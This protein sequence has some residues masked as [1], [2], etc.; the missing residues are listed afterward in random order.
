[1]EMIPERFIGADIPSLGYIGDGVLDALNDMFSPEE[2]PKALLL[3][4]PAG[5]GKTYAMHAIVKWIADQDPEKCVFFS[6]YATYM[7]R[8]R[9]E[10]ADDSYMEPGSW[11]DIVNNGDSA[12]PGVVMLDDVGSSKCSDFEAEKMLM[13]LEKRTAGYEPIIMSTNLSV[14]E[15]RNA[16]G[17][18]VASR[19]GYFRVIVFPDVDL[20]NVRPI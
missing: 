5:C 4:G 20:R 1:M 9:K 7:Q 17:D 8:I 3:T 18:R 10:F 12:Y 19:L 11:W 16:F 15:F 6:D 14:N 2:K 13:L